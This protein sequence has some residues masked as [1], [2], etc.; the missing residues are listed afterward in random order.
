MD[1]ERI[2]RQDIELYKRE[3]LDATVMVGLRETA[4]ILGCHPRTVQRRAD[5]GDLTPYYMGRGTK[6]HVRFLASELQQFVREMRQK[7]QDMG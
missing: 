4:R 6:K 5:E 7:S 2:T 1:R 3:I